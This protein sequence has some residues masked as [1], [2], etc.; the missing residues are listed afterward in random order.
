MKILIFGASGMLGSTL[1]RFLD[2]SASCEVFATVRSS[3]AKK[4]FT[5]SFADR[6]IAGVD[7]TNNDSLLS[8]VASVKP[9][10]VINCIG[11]IKQIIDEADPLSTMQINA[12]L[13]HRL[14][15]MCQLAG[16]RLIHVSTDCVFSGKKGNYSELD[17]SDATD[18]YGKSK[19]IGEVAGKN[20]ITLRTSIIGHELT[21]RRALVDWF[22]SQQG[23]VKGYTR[24][25]FSGVPTVEFARIVRDFV[26]PRSELSGLYHVAAAPIAKY[27]L[28]H[29]IASAYGKDIAIEPDDAVDIDRSLN[30]TLFHEATGYVAP[31][32]QEL[33]IRMRD[34]HQRT[35]LC[36]KKKT[37]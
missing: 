20:V 1:S 30:A 15:L 25:I 35:T 8:V 28:L 23:Q 26:L 12:M 19:F 37:Y 6:L 4:F 34:F 27:D 13:P 21:S 5:E 29:Q 14:A 16:A 36:S 3:D 9:D 22:L 10:V 2:E 32:W 11:L 24:A 18:L 17:S 33:I 7:V 31:P